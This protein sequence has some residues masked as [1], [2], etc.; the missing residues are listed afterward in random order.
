MIA[1][2][3]RPLDVPAWEAMRRDLWPQ[4]PE[5]HAAE[6]AAFFAGSLG[7]PQ[8]VF[9]VEEGSELI[10]V[11]ECSIRHNI[12]G[13]RGKRVGNVEGL[14]VLP[15]FRGSCAVRRLL[16]TAKQWARASGCEGFAS[17]RSDR[18]IVDRRF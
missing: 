4:E 2:P 13:L 3:V 5:D 7:E 15:R 12:D 14:Y 6:I 17:D 10:G 11:I 18:I 9:V 16:A 8:A 1:R